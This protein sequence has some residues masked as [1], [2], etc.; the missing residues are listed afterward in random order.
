MI[1]LAADKAV[2]PTGSSGRARA[3]RVAAAA[4]AAAAATAAAVHGRRRAP[5]RN[6]NRTQT[7]EYRPAPG[8]AAE[9]AA[10]APPR[11]IIEAIVFDWEARLAAPGG[12]AAAWEAAPATA[13]AAV[14]AV[15]RAKAIECN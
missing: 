12:A 8:A 6:I 10:A 11:I 5:A 1:S 15:H 9:A 3:A 4:A 14:T 13:A 2:A 7:I